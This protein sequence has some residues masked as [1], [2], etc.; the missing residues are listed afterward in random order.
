[1]KYTL[2]DRITKIAKLYSRRGISKEEALDFCL[3]EGATKAQVNDHEPFLCSNYD[4][5]FGQPVLEMII[6]DFH[7]GQIIGRN[8][9][10]RAVEAAGITLKQVTK[11]YKRF[12]RTTKCFLRSE[13]H[14]S[15]PPRYQ[16]TF[17]GEV[18]SR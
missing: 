2:T 8:R 9:C 1:M 15:K 16:T 18:S 14:S 7:L 5:E 10:L 4:P 6:R 13:Q 3:C 11:T 17:L 12:Y